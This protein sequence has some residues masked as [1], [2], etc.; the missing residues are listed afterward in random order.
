MIQQSNPWGK[1]RC[2]NHARPD[3]N[4]HLARSCW[5][6]LAHGSELLEPCVCALMSLSKI[7]GDISVLAMCMD[8]HR[9]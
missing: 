3:M 9:A 8:D 2:W 6:T 4:T 7:S 5:A 1:D